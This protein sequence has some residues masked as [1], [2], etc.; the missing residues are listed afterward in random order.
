MIDPHCPDRVAGPF[1][2][3]SISCSDPRT[4]SRCVNSRIF[5][6]AHRAVGRDAGGS[7][8]KPILNIVEQPRRFA[9]RGARTVSVVHTVERASKESQPCAP[10]TLAMPLEPECKLQMH[11][12]ERITARRAT[13][14]C[15]PREQHSPTRLEQAIDPRLVLEHSIDLRP[16]APPCCRR[17]RNQYHGGCAACWIGKRWRNRLTRLPRAS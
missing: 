14:K 7:K 15:R 4:R 17:R 6:F 10:I 8:T 16:A 11:D 3:V 5:L 2:R 1:T 12:G 9:V 13:R